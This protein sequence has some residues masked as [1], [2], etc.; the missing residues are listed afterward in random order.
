MVR[1]RWRWQV[2]GNLPPKAGTR[3]TLPLSVAAPGHNRG[4]GYTPRKPSQASQT[5][6]PVAGGVGGMAVKTV[7]FQRVDVGSTRG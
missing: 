7:A 2:P 3:W 6:L 4:C 1:L 5:K